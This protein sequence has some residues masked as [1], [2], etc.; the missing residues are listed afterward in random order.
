MNK[1]VLKKVAIKSLATGLSS[2]RKQP[3]VLTQAVANRKK[4]SRSY[5]TSRAIN[6]EEAHNLMMLIVAAQIVLDNI[7]KLEN[8]NVYRQTLKRDSVNFI[9]SL[10]KLTNDF[11]WKDQDD[12]MNFY[13]HGLITEMAKMTENIIKLT[14]QA[15]DKI[16]PGQQPLFWREV[17]LIASKFGVKIK[18]SMDGDLL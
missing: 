11:I 6:E 3:E 10:E 9:Q 2:N 13:S 15:K 18:F 1:T 5:R 14:G 12:D 7:L 17:N 16:P 8:T 4:A